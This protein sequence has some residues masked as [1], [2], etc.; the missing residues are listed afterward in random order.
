V[1]A[2]SP[3]GTPKKTKAIMGVKIFETGEI[4]RFTS[5]EFDLGQAEEVARNLSLLAS[6][7]RSAAR[8]KLPA[9]K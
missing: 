8:A 6:D 2:N 9:V 3:R 1:K 5:G 4:E 7:I